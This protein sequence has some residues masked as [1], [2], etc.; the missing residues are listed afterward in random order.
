MTEIHPKLQAYIATRDRR[1]AKAR[2]WSPTPLA[3][4]MAKLQRD[5]SIE[6]GALIHCG[7]A[8]PNPSL[9]EYRLWNEVTKKARALGMKIEETDVK[10]K[11]GSPT[12]NGGFWESR[13]YR[14][15]R[16]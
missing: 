14:L 4:H 13:E 12:Q 5:G 2:P 7:S 8:A 6:V 1:I 11:N 16:A 3:D 10:H 9:V 15:V